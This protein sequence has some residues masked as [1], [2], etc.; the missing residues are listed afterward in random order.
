MPHILDRSDSIYCIMSKETKSF[1]PSVRIWHGYPINEYEVYTPPGWMWVLALALRGV[2]WARED[3]DKPE[4]RATINEY[5]RKEAIERKEVL[6]TEYEQKL[7]NFY[8]ELDE[9]KKNG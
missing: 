8:K 6:I 1:N 2:E 7:E 9:L 3:A 5:Y 4:F